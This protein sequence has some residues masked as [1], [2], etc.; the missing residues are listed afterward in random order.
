[1]AIAVSGVHP[2]MMEKSALAGEDG[3]CT[4]NPLQPITITYEV[5]VCAPAEGADTLTLFHLYQY[6]YSVVSPC[7]KLTRDPVPL[8]TPQPP[9]PLS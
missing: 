9:L 7:D 2:I 3:G 8:S 4:A 5:A 6:M 1:V